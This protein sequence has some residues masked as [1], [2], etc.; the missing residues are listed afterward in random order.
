MPYPLVRSDRTSSPQTMLMKGSLGVGQAEQ[1][2]EIGNAIG[3]HLVSFLPCSVMAYVFTV[4]FHCILHLRD[5]LSELS[6]AHRWAFSEA[7]TSSPRN[8]A[9][10]P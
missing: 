7:G 9:L 10:N 4:C 1:A 5:P 2:R 6:F 8:L 3:G